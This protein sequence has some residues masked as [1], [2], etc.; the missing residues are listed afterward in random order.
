MP[1]SSLQ[2]LTHL[3]RNPANDCGHQSVVACVY[4]APLHRNH[5][6]ALSIEGLM[7]ENLHRLPLS[8]AQHLPEAENALVK[9]KLERGR[10]R[11]VRVGHSLRL[12]GRVHPRP[13][14]QHLRVVHVVAKEQVLE[15]AMPARLRYTQPIRRRG[16]LH[17]GRQAHSISWSP[18]HGS[19]INATSVHAWVQSKV[20][21]AS[22]AQFDPFALETWTR[23]SLTE[24]VEQTLGCLRRMSERFPR[25]V[26][27]I[28]WF[29]VN[30]FMPSAAC[31]PPQA[32]QHRLH[33]QPSCC[34]C[35][36]ELCAVHRK[37]NYPA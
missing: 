2:A 18:P 28:S 35:G 13:F 23:R 4:P 25:T 9:V 37:W 7:P 26:S 19:T 11:V 27:V 36:L 1:C 24:Q 5:Y 14:W 20:L 30:T 33:L 3:H 29:L 6:P 12:H 21:Q 10:G 34:A 15:L 8:A 31:R 22:D 32:R 16:H 17:Q